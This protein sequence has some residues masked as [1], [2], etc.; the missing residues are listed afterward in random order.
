[1][2]VLDHPVTGTEVTQIIEY[3]AKEGK[4]DQARLRELIDAGT[5]K[6]YGDFH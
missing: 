4:L 6:K 3:L 1:V 2:M 5:G